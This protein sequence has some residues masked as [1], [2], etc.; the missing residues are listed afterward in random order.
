MS[1]LLPKLLVLP[2]GL[3][4]VLRSEPLSARSFCRRCCLLSV[5]VDVG[6][7]VG[8]YVGVDVGDFVGVDVG[9]TVGGFV[10]GG[11]GESVGVGVGDGVGGYL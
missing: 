9:D 5:G 11:V 3:L 7:G 1:V 2:S 8:G 4:S 10:G 6:D